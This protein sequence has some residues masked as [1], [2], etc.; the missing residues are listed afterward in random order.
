MA[1]VV[2]DRQEVVMMPVK[3]WRRRAGVL[4]PP[5]P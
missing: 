3:S 5:S 2:D 1:A 4:A